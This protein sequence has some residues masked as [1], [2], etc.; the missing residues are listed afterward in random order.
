[1]AAAS[2]A[3]S[4][5]KRFTAVGRHGRVGR[6]QTALVKQGVQREINPSRPVARAKLPESDRLA[7]V[8]CQPSGALRIDPADGH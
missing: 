8:A 6:Q 1:M 4:A 3:A 5:S 2:G 7:P